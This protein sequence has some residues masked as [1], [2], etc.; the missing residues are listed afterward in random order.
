MI[1]NPVMSIRGPAPGPGRNRRL[2]EEEE[3]RLLEAV[4]LHSN[5][6]LR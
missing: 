5:P 4:D 3:K 1:V 2:T 6:M